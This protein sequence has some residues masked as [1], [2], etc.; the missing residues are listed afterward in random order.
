MTKKSIEKTR[1][2]K[3]IL[4]QMMTLTKVFIILI[5]ILTVYLVLT[6]T[7]ILGVI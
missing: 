1:K 6:E 5:N 7:Q 2:K 3:M 4:K